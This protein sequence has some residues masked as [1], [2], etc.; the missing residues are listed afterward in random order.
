MVYCLNSFPFRDA[1]V[2]IRFLKVRNRTC[3]T[4][5]LFNI[6]FGKPFSYAWYPRFKDLILSRAFSHVPLSSVLGSLC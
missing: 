4:F 5:A 2:F 1:T 6:Q 3:K